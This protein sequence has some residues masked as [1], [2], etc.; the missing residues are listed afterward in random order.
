MAL[1]RIDKKTLEDA[2]RK[3]EDSKSGIPARIRNP[4]YQKHENDQYD[5]T[6]TTSRQ[7]YHNKSYTP[8]TNRLSSVMPTEWMETTAINT[9]IQIE[10]PKERKK[11]NEAYMPSTEQNE[12]D[13]LP[14]AQAIRICEELRTE[15]VFR[16][17]RQTHPETKERLIYWLLADPLSVVYLKLAESIGLRSRDYSID[18]VSLN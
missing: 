3:I 17:G 14:P 2:V 4:T 9:A 8:L 10:K 15:A 13:P 6:D 16:S 18:P 12:A 7:R 1:F 5:P 11:E